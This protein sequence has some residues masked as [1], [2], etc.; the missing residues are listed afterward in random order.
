MKYKKKELSVYILSCKRLHK[1]KVNNS[2]GQ[3]VFY[4]NIV[5]FL[6]NHIEQL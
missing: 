5:V 4:I 6:I 2:E 1:A 3:Y